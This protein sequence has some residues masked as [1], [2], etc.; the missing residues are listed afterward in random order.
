MP[1]I[2]ATWL[3][4]INVAL[5]ALGQRRLTSAQLSTPDTKSSNEAFASFQFH[6]DALVDD[7]PWPFLVSRTT[8]TKD[9]TDPSWGPKYSYALPA[10]CIRVLQINNDPVWGWSGGYSSQASWLPG[11]GYSKWDTELV[12]DAGRSIVTDAE[13]PLEIRYLRSFPATTPGTIATPLFKQVLAYWLASQWS[14][15]FTAS[16]T[17]TQQ[18]ENR[19]ARILAEARSIASTEGTQSPVLTTAWVNSR[20]T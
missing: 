19:F 1:A 20:L 4:T 2:D 9:S 7:H 14:E 10:D 8:L 12:V 11:T 17:L 6:L 15:L 5:S 3:D 18:V 13:S 16:E